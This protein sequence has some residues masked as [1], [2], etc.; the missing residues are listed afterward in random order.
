[1]TDRL[2]VVPLDV[3][4]F[5]LKALSVAQELASDPAT[6]RIVHVLPTLE[7]PA[8][9]SEHRESQTQAALSAF[10]QE[11]GYQKM[12]ITVLEGDPVK[13]IV[14]FA[15]EINAGLIVM[16][17]HGR[18]VF[19]EMLLGSTTYSVVRKAQCPVLVLKHKK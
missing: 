16:P 7:R 12:D 5:S 15:E 19:V 2:V 9:H 6:I 11:H 3:S 4:E 8:L 14:Q 17:S 1:M 13:Q 10:L 18:G